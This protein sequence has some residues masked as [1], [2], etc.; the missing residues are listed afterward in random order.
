LPEKKKV[1]LGMLVNGQSLA[2]RTLA[3]FSSLEAAVFM[4]STRVAVK[5]NG[6]T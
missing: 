3:E 4:L 1:L 5:Q 2:N 6:Q